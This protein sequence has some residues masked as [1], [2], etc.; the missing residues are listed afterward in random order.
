MEESRNDP[1]RARVAI[2]FVVLAIVCV[3]AGFV[4]GVVR[5]HAHQSPH[6]VTVKTTVAVSGST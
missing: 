5:S 3:L 2:L 6:P 1:E 4:V